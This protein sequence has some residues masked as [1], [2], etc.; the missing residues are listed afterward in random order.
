MRAVTLSLVL[1]LTAGSAT[2][3]SAP[4]T[5]DGWTL[6]CQAGRDEFASNCQATRR[7]LTRTLDLVTGDSQVFLSLSAPD[8]RSEARDEQEN[9]WR[10]ELIGLSA[11]KRAAL[12]E[13]SLKRMDAALS[14]RC[15]KAAPEAISLGR[16]PDIA[17]HG[18]P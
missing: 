12:L 2:A 5:H 18:E 6:S 3:A 1:V 10:D 17:V 16:F 14:A 13:R 11:K 15:P 9:W 8:C 7:L 4:E